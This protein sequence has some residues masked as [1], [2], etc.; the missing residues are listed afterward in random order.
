MTKSCF[1]T[2]SNV[3]QTC[4]STFT[5]KTKILFFNI[6]R[7]GKTFWQKVFFF[8]IWQNFVVDF[9][10]LCR[11]MSFL[12][13]ILFRFDKLKWFRIRRWFYNKHKNSD[14]HC[15][16]DN[17]NDKSVGQF[18]KYFFCQQILKKCDLSHQFGAFLTMR[19]PV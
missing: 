14:Q 16:T 7:C 3:E 11:W 2:V 13:L 19:G 1:H 6:D 9:S 10:V 8:Q 18:Q 12:Y 5:K 15:T 4:L 17:L